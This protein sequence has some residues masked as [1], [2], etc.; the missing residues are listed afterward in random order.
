MV[1][2]MRHTAGQMRH[3]GYFAQLMLLQLLMLLLVTGI[4]LLACSFK[5][6]GG[7]YCGAV[8]YWLPSAFCGW[9]IMQG[10]S[11]HPAGSLLRLGLGEMF[12]IIFTVAMLLFAV[13]HAALPLLWL[14][15]GYFAIMLSLCF[16]PGLIRRGIGFSNQKLDLDLLA[17]GERI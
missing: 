10:D 17:K 6:A 11:M 4:L 7:F 15:V 8:A 16:A 12:K 2:S 14:L 13:L 9:L 5:A 1:G 3:Q